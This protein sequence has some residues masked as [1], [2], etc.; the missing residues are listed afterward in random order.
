VREPRATSAAASVDAASEVDLVPGYTAVRV[1]AARVERAVRAFHRRE[2]LSRPAE[3]QPHA[4][5]AYDR[6]REL[7]DRVQSEL[8]LGGSR[9]AP[10]TEY[11]RQRQ[12]FEERQL[13][14]EKAIARRYPEEAWQAVRHAEKAFQYAASPQEEQQARRLLGDAYRFAGR[15]DDAI[16]QFAWL[17]SVE[18]YGDRGGMM[19]CFAHKGYEVRWEN[20]DGNYWAI[21]GGREWPIGRRSAQPFVDAT[22]KWL[23]RWPRSSYLRARLG[24]F[25]FNLALQEATQQSD[26]PQP[27]PE[28]GRR[29]DACIWRHGRPWVEAG[30]REYE[31]AVALAETPADRARALAELGHGSLIRADYDRAISL[32]KETLALE[33]WNRS[34]Q[35]Y[36]RQAYRRRG[37]GQARVV[38]ATRPPWGWYSESP[39]LPPLNA[40][41]ANYGFGSPRLSR[42]QIAEARA[43]I[44]RLRPL[45]TTTGGTTPG[46]DR[47]ADRNRLDEIL[48][49]SGTRYERRT[50]NVLAVDLTHAEARLKRLETLGLIPSR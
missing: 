15:Y 34:A 21:A 38:T 27:G 47:A 1:D 46:S 25:Y 12:E 3:S 32:L 50:G 37:S 26:F 22:Q 11:T 40:G 23:R 35:D 17:A 5:A 30:I 8:P 10:M 43:L 13:Q 45:K 31:R 44:E 2:L 39:G 29:V 28:F 36:L 9:A 33:P 48:P 14:W 6:L 16:R 19:R 49:G 24:G 4:W 41:V 7:L 18:P 20:R 42:D